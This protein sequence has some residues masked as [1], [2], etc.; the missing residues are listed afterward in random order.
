MDQTTGNSSREIT[1]PFFLYSPNATPQ[2]L[3][4]TKLG[5]FIWPPAGATFPSG[6][7]GVQPL[8]TTGHANLGNNWPG[9]SWCD[10]YSYSTVLAEELRVFDLIDRGFDPQAAID[11][12]HSHGYATAAAYYL[13]KKAIGFATGYIALI[14]GRWDR[15][16]P[17]GLCR[18]VFL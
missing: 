7:T 15:V 10:L 9:T 4:A 3:L 16:V 11:W 8:G 17:A 18:P 14:N 12:M 1:I 6:P 2:S 13:S 5:F